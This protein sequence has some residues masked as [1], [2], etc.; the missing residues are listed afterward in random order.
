M[1][2]TFASYAAVAIENNRLYTASQEQAWVSTVMLQI[3]EAAQSLGTIE[4]LLETVVRITP[5]LAGVQSTYVY[6]YDAASQSFNL[7]SWYGLDA[8]QEERLQLESILPGMSVEFDQLKIEMAPLFVNPDPG[9]NSIAGQGVLFPLIAR[10]DL[11]GAFLVGRSMDQPAKNKEA[12]SEQ[13]LAILQG[14]VHQTAVAAE[15]IRLLDS[16]QE[17]A[18]VTAVL[19]QVA[20]AVVSLD[21]LDDILDTIVHLLPIL[22]GVDA[23]AFFLWDPNR[24]AYFPAKV[25]GDNPRLVDEI[26]AN[27]YKPG[28]FPLLDAVKNSET[29]LVQPL[30]G[31]NLTPECWSCVPAS[32]TH[33]DYAEAHLLSP[34]LLLAFPLTVKGEFY[35]A[36]L[37]RE[38]RAPRE[39]YQRRLEIITGVAQ[40]AALAVQD[41]R[42]QAETIVR[43]RLEREIQLARQI[44]QTFLPSEVISPPGWNLDV[45]WQTAR[46]VGGDFYDYFPLPGN[47][48][49]MVVADVSD[50]GMPAALYMTVARTLIRA[51][52]QED[53]SPAQI[54]MRVND[55]LLGDTQTGMFVT[56]IYAELSLDTGDIVYVNAGHNLPVLRR[57]DG[58]VEQ[59]EKGGVA[60]GA[61]EDIT[62][63]NRKITLNNGDCLIFYTDGVTEAF[64]DED[65][66]FGEKR[67]L[68]VVGS[69]KE[70]SASSI[71]DTIDDALQTFIG[72]N[73]PSDDVTMLAVLRSG[74]K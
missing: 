69:S 15:N 63:V 43:E 40:Q 46:Q 26:L 36:L 70:E 72:S 21:N 19:L 59:L 65:E 1:T 37:A 41:D 30:E 11:I 6:L 18:Y 66:P 52:A 67:L 68:E 58:H 4:E 2:S 13:Q 3:T 17:E 47:R 61:W 28:E 54:L 62:L 12:F 23:S 39:G 20:Q 8:S 29:F 60:L 49:A 64:S 50:K 55:L 9:T 56:A 57:A 45:R 73:P 38:T 7:K 42:L 5:M 14:I 51:S 32:E 74:I 22:I 35:G 53:D 34:N 24:G 25:L 10:S 31:E 44:Q 33:W 48:L 16:K 71:L 27:V